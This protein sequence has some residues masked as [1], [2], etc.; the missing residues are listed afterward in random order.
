MVSKMKKMLLLA[1]LIL[2]VVALI[3][4]AAAP[5]VWAEEPECF[6]NIELNATDEDVGVQGYFDWDPWWRLTIDDPEDTRIAKL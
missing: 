1:V 6:F 2:P 3:M 4:G 5:Q